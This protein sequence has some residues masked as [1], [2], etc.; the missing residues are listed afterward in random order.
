MR[1]GSDIAVLHGLLRLAVIAENAAREA[2]EPLVIVAH[3]RGI[4]GGAAVALLGEERCSATC[5]AAA[6]MPLIVAS[7][8]R[9]YWMR[10]PVER[11]PKGA[12]DLT[13]RRKTSF[14]TPAA[15][16]TRAAAMADSAFHDL[17]PALAD[18][19]P[20]RKLTSDYVSRASLDGET[21]IKV[22]PQALTL[23]A[24]QAMIDCQHLLRPGHLQQLRNIL[25][26]A[27][28]SANDKFVAFD[29]LKNANIAAGK[30]L[31]MCQDTGTAIVMGKKGQRV[32]TGGGDA[33]AIAA[34]IR[35]TYTETNLRYAKWRRS[36]CMRR[37]IPATTCRRRSSSMP[38][39]ATSTSC[40]SSPRAAARPI[41]AFSISRRRRCS[42]RNR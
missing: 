38:R 21:V 20:Y 16:T 29:L 35:K 12:G 40:S 4:G 15:R 7:P 36:R 10:Q 41:R 8:L 2:V 23:L 32:W 34:G 17:M 1:E 30:V 39:K 24:A 31:P 27:E 11:F 13:D 3:E 9:R 25:D 18:T 19:T 37:S 14:S 5:P 22:D 42:I 33:A 26:D 28:A 6:A